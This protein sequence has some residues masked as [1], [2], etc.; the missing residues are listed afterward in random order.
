MKKLNIK[1][2]NKT[3]I[4]LIKS[5]NLKIIFYIPINKEIKKKLIF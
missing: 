2:Q 5:K 1:S 4:I 3:L